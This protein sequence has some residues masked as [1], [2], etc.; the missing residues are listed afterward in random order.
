MYAKTYV[1]NINN[2]FIY[3][4]FKLEIIRISISGKMDKESVVYLHGGI[5]N[6]H[7]FFKF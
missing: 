3:N 6:I 5:A 1:K 4:S 2:N 7:F